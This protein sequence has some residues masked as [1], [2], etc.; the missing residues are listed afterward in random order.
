MLRFRHDD[1]SISAQIVYL[2][3]DLLDALDEAA[4][5]IAR[6]GVLA[7]GVHAA[8]VAVDFRSQLRNV[9]SSRN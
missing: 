1:A 5:Q 2:F 6:D 3:V 7:D 8:S 9:P 4:Q